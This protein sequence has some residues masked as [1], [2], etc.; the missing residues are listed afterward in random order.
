MNANHY[1]LS[2][3][4]SLH[5]VTVYWHSRL[6]HKS[7]QCRVCLSADRGGCP[8]HSRKEHIQ[9]S[10]P[11]S[12]PY[13]SCLSLKMTYKKSKNW[14]VCLR[15]NYQCYQQ[16]SV[17]L[18]AHDCRFSTASQNGMHSP[19]RHR[20]LSTQMV[21]LGRF[22]GGGHSLLRPVRSTEEQTFSE[23][24]GLDKCS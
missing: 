13:K 23:D 2:C 6:H 7:P 12:T 1:Q 3:D 18:Q 24:E 10:Y 21:S 9:R 15:R 16:L 17:P 19:F 8:C 4:V 22:S 11:C 20:P 14:N 5:N